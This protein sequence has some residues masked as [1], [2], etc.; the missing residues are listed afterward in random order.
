MFTQNE[1][2][3]TT[4]DKTVPFDKMFKILFIGIKIMTFRY[5]C[6][7]TYASQAVND[8]VKQQNSQETLFSSRNIKSKC[9]I[10]LFTSGMT[11]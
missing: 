11:P 1:Q 10:S 2:I 5:L 3:I 9:C 7:Y 6:N 4:N 8:I